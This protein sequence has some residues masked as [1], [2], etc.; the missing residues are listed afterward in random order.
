MGSCFVK[1]RKPLFTLTH[2]NINN[3]RKNSRLQ[4]YFKSEYGAGTEQ[5]TIQKITIREKTQAIK[6][7]HNR[8]SVGKDGITAEVIKQNQHWLIPQI[9]IILHN[10]Q[11]NYQ[12]PKQWLK[13]VMTFIPKQQKDKTQITNFRPITLINIIYKIWAIIMTNRITPYMGLLTRET[14]TA[15]KTGRSTLDILSLIQNQI[16]HEETKQLLLLDLSKAFDSINRN[17]LWAILY[18]K[19]VPWELIKQIRSGH[20]GNKLCPKYKGVLGPQMYNNKGVFQG[21]PISAM[22]F[23]IYFDHLIGQYEKQLS[24]QYKIQRPPLTIRNEQAEYK[25]CW[26]K[27]VA[28]YRMPGDR[29]IRNPALQEHWVTTIPNDTHVFADD[30]TIKT[31]GAHEIYP[32]LVTFEKQ[33]DKYEIKIN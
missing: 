26:Q 14:Q 24:Q 29:K 7:L 11:Q 15:Y 30:L 13:G 17:I 4:Q 32:K 9:Q 21:S 1:E 18:E 22:L 12:M 28:R 20:K 27:E 10:C 19:G 6:S 3:A 25:W 16:Q 5:T 8:K 2:P 23:I 33:A 31:T